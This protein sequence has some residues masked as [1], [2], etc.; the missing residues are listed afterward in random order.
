MKLLLDT[1]TLIWFWLD[2]PK[3]PERNRQLIHDFPCVVSAVTIWEMVTKHR[4][5]KMPE[6]DPLLP[7]LWDDLE[8]DSFERLPIS[9]EHAFRAAAGRQEHND[10]F[11]RLLAAQAE[12]ENLVF[13]TKDAAFAAFPCATRW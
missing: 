10:P 4:I 6:V 11:D 9:L 1:H 13:L 2:E 3:L 5:G 12:I 8:R 7:R